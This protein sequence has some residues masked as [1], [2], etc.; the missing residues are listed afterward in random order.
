MTPTDS[1]VTS[2]NHAML[3]PGRGRRVLRPAA[4]WSIVAGGCLLD[5]VTKAVV[6]LLVAPGLSSR[7]AY[8]AS[9]AS[10]VVIEGFFYL[11]LRLN[12]GV[13]WSLLHGAS[14]III[15]MLN[16]GIIGFLV[17]LYLRTIPGDDG[18]PVIEGTLEEAA[19]ALILGGAI[20][21]M[22]DRIIYGG[23]RDFLDFVL[24]GF[25]IHYPTFNVADILIC[26]GIALYM[27]SQFRKWRKTREPKAVKPQ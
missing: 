8:E 19:L 4:F 16:V 24:P 9:G 23:V 3:V 18:R 25:R 26:V 17:Y 10:V 13:A 22:P 12:R 11:S 6:V 20:G 27:W 21:N 15:V 2:G 5:Q 14:P 1:N 7:E